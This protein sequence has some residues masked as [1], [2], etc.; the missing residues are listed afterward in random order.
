MAIESL[1]GARRRKAATGTTAERDGVTMTP[2]V[3]N[4]LRVDMD[5]GQWRRLVR[6]HG[7]DVYGSPGEEFAGPSTEVRDED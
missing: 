1:D 4:A 7:L 6:R 5:F 3:A 2:R